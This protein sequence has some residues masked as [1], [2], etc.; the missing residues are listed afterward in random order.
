VDDGQSRARST[1]AGTPGTPSRVRAFALFVATAG[2]IG[3]APIAPGTWGSLLV[4][5]LVPTLA[6]LGAA[7]HVAVVVAVVALGTWAAGEADVAF[8]THDHGRVVVDEVGGM[9][10]GSLVVP[11]TWTAAWLLFA[12]FRLFDVWK[13]FPAN[14][15]D[16]TWRGGLGVVGDDLVAGLY[17]GVACRV[18]LEVL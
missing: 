6:T 13:P 12:L 16:R 14:H 7:A 10:V 17:A 5:P 3:Y 4:V 15:I 8:G 2:G 11:G 18:V 1:H 9:L